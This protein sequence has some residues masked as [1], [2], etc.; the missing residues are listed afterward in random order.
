MHSSKLRLS[1]PWSM[2]KESLNPSHLPELGPQLGLYLTPAEDSGLFVGSNSIHHQPEELYNSPSRDSWQYSPQPVPLDSLL[3]D[4]EPTNQ[5]YGDG[6]NLQPSS[7]ATY[8]AT[9][10]SLEMGPPTNPSTRQVPQ[11]FVDISALDPT[12]PLAFPQGH[13]YSPVEYTPT[14]SGYAGYST[15]GQSSPSSGG[16]LP[17]TTPAMSPLA[18][19]HTFVNHSPSSPTSPFVNSS[20]LQMLPNFCYGVD[21]AP[22]TVP[23][24]AARY[25]SSHDG[26][27]VPQ[28]TYRPHTQ[29]DR[30]RYVEE[31][32]LEEPIMFFTTDPAVC[33]I[34]LCDALTSKFMRLVGRDD[35]MFVNRG[36]SVSIRLM[37]PGYVPW[38]RQIPTRDFRTPPGPITRSKLAK[39]VAKTIQRFLDE[40]QQQRMEEDADRRWRVGNNHIRLEHLVLVGLQHVSMGSWQAYIRLRRPM[41]VPS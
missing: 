40:M 5:S 35:L 41:L 7:I 39:N 4:P 20:D 27:L 36:P 31:V 13:I 10:G 24:I 26:P 32:K 14:S 11:I 21:D 33:G 30:R 28:R 17:P 37:W 23:D 16:S 25:A 18:G 38:S 3:F 12:P 8:T 1:D 9:D 19:G 6:F 2:E 34:P 15:L 29:S 22:Q